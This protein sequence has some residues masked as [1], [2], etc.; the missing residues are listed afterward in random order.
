MS[1]VI[2]LFPTHQYIHSVKVEA[3]YMRQELMAMLET[4]AICRAIEAR[5]RMRACDKDLVAHGLPPK[6]NDKSAA[7]YRAS[8]SQPFNADF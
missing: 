4:Q 5:E 6:F 2:P 1:N 7:E 8:L 3:E